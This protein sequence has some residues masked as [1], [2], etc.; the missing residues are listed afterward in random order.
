MKPRVNLC[1]GGYI[2]IEKT[3]ALTTV[4][5]NSGSFTNLPNSR[6]TS[7]WVNYSAIHEV[8]KQIRLRNIGE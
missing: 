8:I 1:R 3:E 2:I 5:V 7:L 4:D 6:Q